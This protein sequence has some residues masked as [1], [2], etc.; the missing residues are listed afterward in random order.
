MIKAGDKVMFKADFYWVAEDY[1]FTM[2]KAYDVLST[3]HFWNSAKITND[4]GEQMSFSIDRL[5]KVEEAV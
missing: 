5:M 2:G 3:H 1:N 4:L